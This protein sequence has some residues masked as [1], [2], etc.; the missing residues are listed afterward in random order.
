MANKSSL[1]KPSDSLSP[2]AAR[3]RL[4]LI[5][6]AQEVLAEIG[7]DATVEQFVGYAKVSP[8]T[9][10]NHF[11][12]KE[13]LF[14]EAL[15]QAWREWID[16]A[17]GGVPADESLEVAIDV[18]RR[19]FR[20]AKT[21]PE[22]SR[23][24]SKALVNPAFIIDAVQED[25]L[26]AAKRFARLGQINKA[27]FDKRIRLFSYCVTGILSSV[28]TTNELSPSEADASLVI[29]LGILGVSTAKAKSIISRPLEKWTY[30]A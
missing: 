29:A 19:L 30:T 14:K 18:C 20:V 21:H 9:I 6:S 8:T 15:A 24:I 4:A 26:P 12:N 17:H 22:F 2:A 27:E 3:N 7:P 5:K 25:A 28:H 1:E 23:L 11:Y 13:A 10:Y 16:W